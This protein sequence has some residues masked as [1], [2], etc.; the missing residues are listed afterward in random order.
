MASE[1]DPT[2][3]EITADILSKFSREGSIIEFDVVLLPM[4]DR[5]EKRIDGIGVATPGVID[6]AA[7]L[8]LG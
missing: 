2:H 8:G 5:I 6:L 4:G 1:L 3:V 7:D